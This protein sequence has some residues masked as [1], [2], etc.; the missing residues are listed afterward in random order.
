LLAIKSEHA[1]RRKRLA[2]AAA[3]SWAIVVIG[4]LV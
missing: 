3:V 4:F 2:I 1:G